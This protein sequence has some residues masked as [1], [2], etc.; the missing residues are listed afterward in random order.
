[1]TAGEQRINDDVYE[2][3][4]L[5][6]CTGKRPVWWKELILLSCIPFLMILAKA[7]DGCLNRWSR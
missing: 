1:M 6:P 2:D 4:Y 7:M 5:D 3:V